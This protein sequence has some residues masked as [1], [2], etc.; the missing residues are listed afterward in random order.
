MKTDDIRAR[1][2]GASK[3]GPSWEGLQI[4]LLCDISDKLTALL[5]A[6]SCSH[7]DDSEVGS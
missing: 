2:M 4:L 6:T 1:V 7:D 3:G 5:D